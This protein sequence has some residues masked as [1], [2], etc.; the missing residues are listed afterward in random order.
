MLGCRR[1]FPHSFP[2]LAGG[3]RGSA[4][5][6]PVIT[7]G[8]RSACY[9]KVR[10]MPTC[11][12]RTRPPATELGHGSTNLLVESAHDEDD[13]SVEVSMTTA[14]FETM[15]KVGRF[16]PHRR[17]RI[18]VNLTARPYSPPHGGDGSTQRLRREP[19]APGRRARLVSFGP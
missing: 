3:R 15:A 16:I 11:L 9:Q 17:A 7:H 6:S 8:I 13:D 2:A 18:A 1:L 19:G 12:L 14:S 5:I 4:G 10:Q